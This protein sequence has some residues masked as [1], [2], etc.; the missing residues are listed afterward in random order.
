VRAFGDAQTELAKINQRPGVLIMSDQIRPAPGPIQ[1]DLV[2][3]K[4]LADLHRGAH[5]TRVRGGDLVIKI[6][7]DG[8]GDR[9][10]QPHHGETVI[11]G[12][13]RS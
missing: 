11:K 1:D 12:K 7:Y 3:P 10:A 8:S 2:E 9:I 4:W 5:G 13:E 6:Y